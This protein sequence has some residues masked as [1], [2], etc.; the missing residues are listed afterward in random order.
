MVRV[1]SILIKQESTHNL[2]SFLFLFAPTPAPVGGE[3]INLMGRSTFKHHLLL[4]VCVF[5]GPKQSEW[6]PALD[7]SQV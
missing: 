7:S 2:N 3:K 4:Y 6:A 5:T 1:Q